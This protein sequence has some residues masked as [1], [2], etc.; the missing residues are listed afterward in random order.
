MF[1]LASRQL[2]LLVV[3]PASPGDD[4]IERAR[5]AARP[6]NTNRS[7]VSDFRAYEH[8]CIERPHESIGSPHSLGRYLA[9]LAAVGKA[10]TLRRRLHGINAEFELRFGCRSPGNSPLIR[11]VLTGLLNDAERDPARR[12]TPKHPA[13]TEAVRTVCAS[14]DKERDLYDDVSCLLAARDRALILVSYAGALSSGEIAS[15]DCGAI[16]D[17][18]VGLVVTVNRSDLPRLARRATIH[19]GAHL[20]TDP[21]EALRLW[22]E[23]A[24]IDAGPIFRAIDPTGQVAATRLTTRAIS[25]AITM[26]FDRAGFTKA[27]CS[28]HSLRSGFVAQTARAG[29]R[30]RDILDATGLRDPRSIAEV[31]SLGRASRPHPGRLLGL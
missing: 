14:I 23:R 20:D 31:A 3:A 17:V 15:L 2:P 12:R 10:S 19:R 4:P 27:L 9:A 1:D 6:R 8:W 21:V 30:N 26:R 28:S 18:D 13:V 7:Y 11:E 24:R 16:E 5:R 29:A 22:R 25:T